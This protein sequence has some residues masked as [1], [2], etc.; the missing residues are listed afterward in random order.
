MPSLC[1]GN[2][3]QHLRGITG[4]DAFI[5]SPGNSPVSDCAICSESWTPWPICLPPPP[6]ELAILVANLWLCWN[7]TLS[8]DSSF[9]WLP[10]LSMI[11]VSSRPFDSACATTT[12][13]VS[14][15]AEPNRRPPWRWLA[16]SDSS[17][18]WLIWA[19]PSGQS[20]AQMGYVA[21]LS[22]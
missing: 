10:L 5:S 12:Y 21:V 15:F 7:A 17:S 18:P 22:C 19:R 9:L 11:A 16:N 6:S 4:I 13:C 3:R 14:G 2:W 20:N 1:L 8:A